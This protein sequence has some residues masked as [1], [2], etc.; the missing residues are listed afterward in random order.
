MRGDCETSGSIQK[1]END[2]D[3]NSSELNLAFKSERRF[4]K[5]MG[6]ETLRPALVLDF[7]ETLVFAS[8]IRSESASIQIRVHRRRLWVRMRPGLADFI[9]SVSKLF[10]L[11]FFTASVSEYADPIVEAIAPGAPSSHR[12]TRADCVALCGYEVKDLRVIGRPLNEI[13]LVD[14]L[15]G[16]ALMH[17]KNLIRIAPWYGTDDTDSVLLKQL[18][19]ALEAIAEEPD[20]PAA[21][22]K[23][24]HRR[25][26][27][28]LHRAQAPDPVLVRDRW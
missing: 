19:P 22:G 15:E 7:D 27:P 13:V 11:Y 3:L 2:R 28:D 26:F 17:P 12:F 24:L 20:L 25:T 1:P 5:P 9:K 21:I 23:V 16:S 18:L 10:D 14:D 6:R 8:P 4:Q